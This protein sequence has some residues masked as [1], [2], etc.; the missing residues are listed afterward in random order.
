MQVHAI[1]KAAQYVHFTSVIANA[2]PPRCC[3]SQ[4][5][6]LATSTL[7]GHHVNYISQFSQKAS[8]PQGI[9]DIIITDFR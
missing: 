4:N 5:T 2:D 1:N 9:T 3:D 8:D 7:H 6:H